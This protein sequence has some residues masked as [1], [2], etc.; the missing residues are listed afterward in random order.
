MA[1]GG[2]P[3][4]SMK[5]QVA[6]N[7]A[8]IKSDIGSAPIPIATP[9]STGM[10]VAAVAV[11]DVTSVRN[12]ISVTTAAISSSTGSVPSPETCAP[13]HWSSPEAATAEASDSPPPNS[14][15]TPHGSPSSASFHSSTIRPRPS[16]GSRNSA[17][18]AAMAM[19]V[20]SSEPSGPRS[21]P[22]RLF[23][24][25]G[26]THRKAADPNTIITIRSP[27]PTG[28]RPAI[29]SSIICRPPGISARLK[30]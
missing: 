29:C 18:P 15:S 24:S 1:L 16:P 26:T 12:R 2:V 9:P 5:A 13:N 19:A 30:G 8:G 22:T 6:A 10:K 27:W 14:S 21:S 28:P 23:N 4:G 17:I 11:F 3:T 7:A 20:S 25:P